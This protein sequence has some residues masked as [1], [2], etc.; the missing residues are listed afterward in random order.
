MIT[1][2]EKQVIREETARFLKTF[3]DAIR[4]DDRH[5][6]EFDHV[7][8]LDSIDSVQPGCTVHIVQTPQIPGK[9]VRFAVIGDTASCFA[10]SNMFI[11]TSMQLFS[12]YGHITCELFSTGAH[13]M[14]WKH[15]IVVVPGETCRIDITN[16][17]M[18]PLRFF[19]ALFFLGPK[20]YQPRYQ[21]PGPIDPSDKGGESEPSGVLSGELD[22]DESGAGCY[23]CGGRAVHNAACPVRAGKPNHDGSV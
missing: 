16:L 4:A 15:G 18:L 3:T 8:P 19:G 22:T 6:I 23:H 7:V 5:P 2:A 20:P 14:V 1:E 11:G 12:A 10:I 21:V 9:L 17:S 13:P